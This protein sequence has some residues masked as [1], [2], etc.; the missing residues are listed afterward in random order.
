MHF[1]NVVYCE[2]ID[3]RAQCGY[4]TFV[5]SPSIILRLVCNVD[6]N[7]LIAQICDGFNQSLNRDRRADV[8]VSWADWLL[9][10]FHTDPD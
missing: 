8:H 10:Y 3:N 9:S 5:Q 7:V 6:V 2:S 4:K 1:L